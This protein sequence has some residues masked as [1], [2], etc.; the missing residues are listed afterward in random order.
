MPWRR[1]AAV[2]GGAARAV[3]RFGAGGPRVI[4][5]SHAIAEVPQREAGRA[6]EPEALDATP[7]AS[8]RVRV[9]EP[10]ADSEGP[11]LEDAR[12]VVS[13]GRGLQDRE[14]FGLIRELAAALGGMPGASRAIVDDGWAPASEQVGLTGKIVAPDLYIAIGISGASQHMA[15]CSNARVIVGVNSGPGGADLP[16]RALRHRRRLPRRAARADPARARGGRSLVAGVARGGGDQLIDP[17]ELADPA[18]VRPAGGAVLDLHAHSRER[19]LDSGVRALVIAEQAALRGLDGICLTEHNALWSAEDARAMSERHGVCVLPGMELGTD[20]GHLL[21][22]GLPRF[23]PELLAIDSLRP[24]VEA[25]GAAMALAHPMRPF[26]GRLPG[27]DEMLR[28]VSRAR[29]DQRG[30]FGQRGRPVRASRGP[31]RPRG[32]RRQRR[33]QPP[34]GGARGHLVQRAHRRRG[35]A[36]AV[37]PRRSRRA[38]R[39]AGRGRGRPERRAPQAAPRVSQQWGSEAHPPTLQIC[40]APPHAP[41]SRKGLS[42]TIPSESA[43]TQQ[44]FTDGVTAIRG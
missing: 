32:G 30:S 44:P 28:V 25:E 24:I 9:L 17:A 33:A 31:S 6:V 29:G 13:G 4:G 2:F 18:S 22:F 37:A 19:S 38:P 3:Y 41:V 40:G 20:I 36:G 8:E 15:V 39:P 23:T 5:V 16:L 14:H 10:A 12:V 43:P 1:V 11:R 35:D 21:V 34:G 7:P 26:S 27:W 42:G